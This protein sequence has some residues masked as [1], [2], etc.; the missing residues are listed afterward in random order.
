MRD[1][2]SN[3]LISVYGAG[4]KGKKSCAPKKKHK[5]SG[6]KRGSGSKHGRS[7]SRRRHGSS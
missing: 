4:G 3:E 2:N 7:G 6:S 5:G 1:L